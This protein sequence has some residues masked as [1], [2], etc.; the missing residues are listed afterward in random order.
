MTVSISNMSQVWMSNT[1]TYNSIA[2]SVSTLGAGANVNSRLLT[3]KVD[4][5]TKFDIDADGRVGVGTNNPSL[6]ASPGQVVN[7]NSG[8]A[9]FW[10]VGG[11]VSSYLFSSNTGQVSAVGTSSN[12]PFT[13]YTNGTERMRINSAG[14]I[15][16]GTTSPITKLDVAGDGSFRTGATP[17]NFITLA[18]SDGSIEISRNGGGA[19][20][21]FKNTAS[22][23]NDCRIQ[24]SGT[25]GD[26]DFYSGSL[27]RMRIDSSGRVTMPFMPAFWAVGSGTQSWSG[28]AT[29]TK[30]NFASG[31]QYVTSN[32]SAGWSQANSRYTAPVGG[33]YE[34]MLSFAVQTGPS[35]GPAA[36][37]YKNGSSWLEVVINYASTSYVQ[38][39]GT[40]MLDLNAND[41]VEFWIVNYN[42]TSFTIDL[43]RCKFSGKLIG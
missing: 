13:F 28:A 26:L 31:A 10:T 4:G 6:Y 21:D 24:S 37:L 36:L 43:G 1:N 35:T 17:N 29:Y 11:N 7:Y 3:L 33:T 8:T 5:S 42:N 32:K 2:M 23:D 12:H 27:L 41:Y 9:A 22:E 18:A 14:N 34:F 19:Y 16:I 25:T 38:T 40:I 30:V 39:T 20:I 15:G